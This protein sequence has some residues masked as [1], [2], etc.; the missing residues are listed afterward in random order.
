MQ[1]EK[2]PLKQ[3]VFNWNR[4]GIVDLKARGDIEDFQRMLNSKILT[5]YKH[6]I[7]AIAVDIKILFS[8]A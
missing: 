1:L 7:A 3:I 2:F 6:E 5:S 4:L 8:L